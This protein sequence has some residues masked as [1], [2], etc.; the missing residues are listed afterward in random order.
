MV[1]API[2]PPTRSPLAI[3]VARAAGDYT[4]TVASSV[5]PHAGNA[6]RAQGSARDMGERDMLRGD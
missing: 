2:P 3:V 4:Q 6:V 5:R 1:C